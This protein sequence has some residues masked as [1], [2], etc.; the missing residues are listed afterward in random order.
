MEI[1]IKGEVSRKN[2][3]AN[4]WDEGETNMVGRCSKRKITLGEV[5]FTLD[6]LKTSF[7]VLKF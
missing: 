6:T 5:R 3:I 4:G 1:I 7:F 2:V